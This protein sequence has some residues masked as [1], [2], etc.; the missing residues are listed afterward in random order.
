MR[1]TEM[2]EERFQK[3][4]KVD[5]ATIDVTVKV[6]TEEAM[7]QA[8]ELVSLFKTV[9]SL[10]DELIAIE[11]ELQAIRS[12]LEFKPEI[13]VDGKITGFYIR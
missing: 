12:S 11:K 13:T 6:D 2:I 9:N 1:F 7:N 3:I 4:E 10:A 5:K 8:K